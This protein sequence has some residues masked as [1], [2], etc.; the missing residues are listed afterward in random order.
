VRAGV[1]IAVGSETLA[2]AGAPARSGVSAAPETSTAV[3]TNASASHRLHRRIAITLLGAAL[4]I[5][6]EAGVTLRIVCK[7]RENCNLTEDE[8]RLFLAAILEACVSAPGARS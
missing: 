3:S 5:T 4:T 6:S 8:D 1:G 2:G 7:E